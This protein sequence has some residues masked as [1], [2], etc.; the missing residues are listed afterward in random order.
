MTGEDLADIRRKA[1][2]TQAELAKRARIGRHAVSYWETQ[3]EVRRN[4]W[5]VRRMAEVIALP[6]IAGVFCAR[7]AWGVSREDAVFIA[8][9]R[10]IELREAKV[11]AKRR[12]LCGATTRKGMPCRAKSGPG[13]RRCRFH[14]GLST[15]PRTPEGKERIR[16]AM[17]DRWARWR[18][19]REG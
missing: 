16:Q 5:A 8:K 2:L 13:R 11:K 12:V 4:A 6:D 1:G 19:E 3:A 18:A 10:R 9:A 14:G 7:A 17:R 15:G